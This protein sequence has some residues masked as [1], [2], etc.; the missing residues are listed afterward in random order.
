MV[1][2]AY[3]GAIVYILQKGSFRFEVLATQQS[4]AEQSSSKF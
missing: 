4:R 1:G 3:G 2:Y